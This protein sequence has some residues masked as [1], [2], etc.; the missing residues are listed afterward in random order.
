VIGG[1]TL[2]G[3]GA[4]E[5]RSALALVELCGRALARTIEHEAERHARL[6]AEASAARLADELA[7]RDRSL[8]MVVHDLRNPLSAIVM[9]A[10]MLA[11]RPGAAA[12]LARIG[13]SADRMQHM[14]DQ[15]LDFARLRHHAPL[16]LE[17][18]PIDLAEVLADVVE[19]ARLAFPR[20]RIELAGAA[21]G[22]VRGVWDGER[23]AEA[24]A[25]LIANA[26][27]HGDP[28]AAVRVRL[29]DD[30][31]RVSIDVENQG[32]AIPP[33]ALA[34]IFE[35]FQR[36][37]IAGRPRRRRGLGLGLYITRALIE[38]HGGAVEVRSG[39]DGTCFRVTLPRGR[40]AR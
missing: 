37:A 13:R 29:S 16:T 34:R 35:P 28:D 36:P 11:E 33:E 6:A 15:L 31:E 7:L 2:I 22:E 20:A 3:A 27:E 10:R 26:I 4:R 19:E 23:V 21:G 39:S 32:P 38:A 5:E 1:L 9:S 40:S 12:S 17:P 24:V 14:I 8:A 18:R 25:N 30:R